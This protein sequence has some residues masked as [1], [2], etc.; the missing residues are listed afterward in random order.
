LQFNAVQQSNL[1]K[2]KQ[3]MTTLRLIKSMGRS[4]LRLGFLLIPLTLGC[5]ALSPLARATCRDDCDNFGTFQG[6]DALI[7]NTLGTGNTA[8]GWRSLFSNTDASFSTG[9]GGGA[10][11]LNNADSNTAVGAAALLLNTSGTENTAVGTDALVFNDTGSQN[12][13][14]GA[15]AL[16]DNVDGNFN[17]AT[18]AQA[19]LS[20]TTGDDNMASGYSALVNNTTGIDNVAVGFAALLVNVTGSNNTGIGRQALLNSTGSGNTALGAGA[21]VLLSTGDNNIDINNEGDASDSDTIR[22][23]NATHGRIFI[24]A[25]NNIVLGAGVAVTID[26]TTGL[27]GLQASSRRFK[28]EIK[29]MDQ[30]SEALFDLKPVTFRYKKEIDPAGTSQLGLVAEEVEK[31]NPALVLRDKEGKPYSVRYDQVNAMLLNE[32]LKAHRRMEKQDKRIEELTAQL[33]EQAA[34]IQKVSAQL[35]ASKPAPQVVNN[36]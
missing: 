23:G 4:P 10:L 26:S 31:V 25:I 27:L 1:N 21:G 17:T 28:E 29:P 2:K 19:L 33:K 3:N 20:N 34:Q 5:F 15:F 7:S 8:F 11:S 35:E 14:N 32:F 30:V 22:I 36:P 12:T 13:A 9:V 16:F 24:P 18:G 6:D